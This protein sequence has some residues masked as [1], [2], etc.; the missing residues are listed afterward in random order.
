MLYITTM[1]FI[2]KTVFGSSSFASSLF[3]SEPFVIGSCVKGTSID[4]I[5]VKGSCV[6][7]R[8][9][10]NLE[11]TRGWITKEKYESNR[12]NRNPYFTGPTYESNWLIRKTASMGGFAVGGYPDELKHLSALK[13]AGLQTFV[14]LN[15]EYGKTV[16]G[17]SFWSYGYQL[18][19]ANF[20]YEPINDMDTVKDETVIALAQ[21]IVD[22]LL[23]G[24]SVYLHC[25][26][27]HGRTGTVALV[28]LHIL[29]PELTELELFEFVQYAHDQRGG[30]YF[31]PGMFIGKM[32]ADPLAHHFGKSQVPTPQTLEQRNQVRR[33]NGSLD[34]K[35]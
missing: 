35:P 20:I 16:K 28:V 24:E 32:F 3:S 1:E 5:F 9:L 11:V 15:T 12:T 29:Y 17:N 18:L 2:A 13:A 14:C 33:I 10:P 7:T 31:G 26:G 25:A 6:S 23:K 22:R 21:K 27:G 8:V 4:G 19:K 34:K 30:N